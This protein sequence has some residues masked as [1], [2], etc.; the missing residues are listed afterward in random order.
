MHVLLPQGGYLQQHR[1]G[2]SFLSSRWC[3]LRF[4][5]QIKRWSQTVPRRSLLDDSFQTLRCPELR[6]WRKMSP[7]WRSAPELSCRC[8]LELAA[9][10]DHSHPMIYQPKNRYWEIVKVY[11]KGKVLPRMA[12]SYCN[13]QQVVDFSQNAKKGV[14]GIQRFA[15]W[16]QFVNWL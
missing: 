5:R 13:T 6:L 2:S 16:E 3:G 15:S 14:P 12:V 8:S 4:A 9:S 11:W 1:E 10:L 7:R